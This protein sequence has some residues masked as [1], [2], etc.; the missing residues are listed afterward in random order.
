MNLPDTLLYSRT[1]EWVRIADG[2]ATVG[3]TDHAQCEL[4]DVV[5]VEF[6]AVGGEVRRDTVFGTVE[7]V[8]AVSDLYAPVSGEVLEINAE[9]SARTELVNEDP[10]G[11]GWMVRIAVGANAETGHLMSAADYEASVQESGH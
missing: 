1:H 6:P 7:S 2:I 4:G 9:L 3:I 5:Y 8:K 11:E 10:Y